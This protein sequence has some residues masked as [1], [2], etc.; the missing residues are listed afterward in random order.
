M[1]LRTYAENGF[2]LL[3]LVY[4]AYESKANQLPVHEYVREVHPRTAAWG[5]LRGPQTSSRLQEA[6]R[7]LRAPRGRP[8]R[9]AARS[10]P[11]SWLRLAALT[12]GAGGVDMPEGAAKGAQCSGHM[13]SR[14]KAISQF[15]AITGHHWPSLAIPG[16][17]VS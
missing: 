17:L 2:S 9:G 14:S 8:V 3:K 5:T 10:A 1:R 11:P 16:H 4:V 12:R 7:L 13:I 6:P 15:L